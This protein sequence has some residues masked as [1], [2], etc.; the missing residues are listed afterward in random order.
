M[1]LINMQTSLRL[2]K[3]TANGK[4]RSHPME[5]PKTLACPVETV[6]APNDLIG[7]LLTMLDAEK[8]RYCHWKSNWKIERW[9]RAE[10]DLDLLIRNADVC[11]FTSIVSRMGFKKSRS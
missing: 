10:G 1:F 11:Q 6:C 3:K 5:A 2:L 9:L 7:D 4:Q 8:I